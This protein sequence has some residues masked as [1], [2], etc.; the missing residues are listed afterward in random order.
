MLMKIPQDGHHRGKKS[1]Y[2]ES[3]V[4]AG[5]SSIALRKIDIA[6]IHRLIFLTFCL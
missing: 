4:V 1:H 6:K 3:V 2:W 5:Q